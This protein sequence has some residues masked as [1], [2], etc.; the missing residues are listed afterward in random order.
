MVGCLFLSLIFFRHLTSR[1]YQ[2]TS[3]CLRADKT[4]PNFCQPKDETSV[5]IHINAKVLSS[6][7]A[8]NGQKF[9][10]IQSPCTPP[11]QKQFL[12]D[13]IQ[14]RHRSHT[15]NFVESFPFGFLSI[16]HDPIQKWLSRLDPVCADTRGLHTR[17]NDPRDQLWM[18]PCLT[19]SI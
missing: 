9:G 17:H 3:H 15:P 1:R 6:E 7:K 14:T 10:V 5:L 8:L 4:H 11:S 18:L 16:H 13:L 19:F 12:T 2:S